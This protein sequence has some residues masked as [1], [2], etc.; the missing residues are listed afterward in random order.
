MEVFPET[1]LISNPLKVTEN[2][3]T[4]ITDFQSGRERRLKLWAFPKRSISLSHQTIKREEMN[5]IWQFYHARCGAWDP[6]WFLLPLPDTWNK[7]YVGTGDNTTQIFDLPSKSTTPDSVTVY[8]DEVSVLF[9]FL[10][11]GGQAECDR[12]ELVIPPSLGAV[13]TAD[14]YGNLRLKT[15]FAMDNL[16]KDMFAYLLFNAEVGLMEVKN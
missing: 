4:R 2:W 16:T 14:F 7:E 15:R 1:V 9:N 3:K 12:V 6:F 13:I 8:V 11:G 5:E 10:S